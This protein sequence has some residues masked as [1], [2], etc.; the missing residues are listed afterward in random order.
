MKVN[1]FQST[2]VRDKSTFVVT[3]CF[4]V[5]FITCI[6]ALCIYNFIALN[7]LFSSL[8]LAM[9]AKKARSD[10][11][12]GKRKIVRTVSEERNYHKT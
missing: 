9:G 2:T 10:I 1:I 4:I 8:A 5:T 6:V 3:M 12:Q 11:G 7:V